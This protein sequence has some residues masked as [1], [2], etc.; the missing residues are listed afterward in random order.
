MNPK[1]NKITEEIE[2]VRT[3][4]TTYQARLRDLEHQKTELENADIVAMIRGINISPN[5]FSEFVRMFKEQ[6]NC[7]V[8]D[9]P[10]PKTE[11][12]ED[13]MIEN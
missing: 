10:S 6:Q 1:I 8:P 13:L 9:I 12:E 5:E 7:A 4:I 11:T 2:K 3:K